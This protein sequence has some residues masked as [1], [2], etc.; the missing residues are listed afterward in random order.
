[1]TKPLLD[2]S[3]L[4]DC[5]FLLLIYFLVT[6]TIQKREQDL[7]MLL[8]SGP[9]VASL[10]EPLFIRVDAGGAVAVGR[11]AA[12]QMLDRDPGVRELP[13]LRQ[14]L[15]MFAAA[16]AGA[17]IQPLVQ[18]HVEGDARQ[19]RVVDV[20]NALAGARI[21]RVTFTDFAETP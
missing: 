10:I 9:G 17:G 4:I 18:I 6:T 21:E 15:E 19:Q 16:A 12:E 11:G 2:I 7:D 5:T 3:S 1:M 20:L 8:P 14:H 13:L